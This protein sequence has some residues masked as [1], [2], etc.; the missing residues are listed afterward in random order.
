MTGLD[1][2]VPPGEHDELWAA[3]TRAE[4]LITRLR[5][6]LG[7]CDNRVLRLEVAV[8]RLKETAEK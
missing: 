3:I 1:P 6:V 4:A 8:R 2:I 5:S 7:E